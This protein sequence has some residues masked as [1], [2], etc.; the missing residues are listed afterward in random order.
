MFYAE[1]LSDIDRQTHNKYYCSA[2]RHV[3][4]FDVGI[5]RSLRFHSYS[6]SFLSCLTSFVFSKTSRLAVT[7]TRTYCRL[8][9]TPS[10]LD[11]WLI[12]MMS[13]ERIRSPVQD[14]PHTCPK[15]LESPGNPP[16][17]GVPVGGFSSCL[18]PDDGR[19]PQPPAVRFD[20]GRSDSRLTEI[21]PPELPQDC[22]RIAFGL[23]EN[24]RGLWHV[25]D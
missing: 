22:H 19:P 4:L 12:G 8:S 9:R 17:A 6:G 15:S 5:I 13:W 23:S 3:L 2:I 7:G 11:E 24:C 20:A 25:N 18:S 16:D 14:L 10:T 1:Y 21:F